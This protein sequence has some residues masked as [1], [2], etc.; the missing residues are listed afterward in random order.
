MFQAPAA[1]VQCYKFLDQSYIY[2]THCCSHTLSNRVQK[3]R[4][5]EE[6]FGSNDSYPWLN[7]NP[8]PSALVWKVHK[9]LSNIFTQ[10]QRG[11]TAYQQ[12]YE[13]THDFQWT[14]S[15]KISFFLPARGLG[16]SLSFSYFFP[17]GQRHSLA[18]SQISWRGSS[19]KRQSW[20]I[21]NIERCSGRGKI[22]QECC[23]EISRKKSGSSLL[24]IYLF[25]SL[26]ALL[27]NTVHS[28]H[29]VDT[30]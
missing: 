3:T 22:F 14:F 6:I 19:R 7:N 2:I 13:K 29:G 11:N 25:L 9:R 8:V 20:N 5:I 18:S 21:T 24:L 26:D 28:S 27:V 10:Y 23:L 4:I 17:R 30:F 12:I 15:Q 1:I 16:D